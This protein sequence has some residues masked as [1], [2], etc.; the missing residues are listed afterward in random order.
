MK[1]GYKTTE[2]WTSIIAQIAGMLV[3]FGVVEQES[4]TAISTAATQIAGGI[5][6]GAGAFGYAVSRGSAKR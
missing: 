2:F 6:T 4:A 3:L 5:V 1:T